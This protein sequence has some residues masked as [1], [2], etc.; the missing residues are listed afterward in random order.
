MSRLPSETVNQRNIQAALQYVT[1]QGDHSQLIMNRL[2]ELLRYVWRIAED[3]EADKV[4]HIAGIRAQDRRRQLR[5]LSKKL[6]NV[7]DELQVFRSPKARSKAEPNF[8]PT[9]PIGLYQLR[10]AAALQLADALSADFIGQFGAEPIVWHR[11]DKSY[12]NIN[13][14]NRL[15]CIEETAE[16][17]IPV[18]LERLSDAL[19]SAAQDLAS[20]TP[21]GGPRA[22]RIRGIILLNV[23]AMWQDIHG[24]KKPASYNR[25]QTKFF[26]FCAEICRSIKFGGECTEAHLRKAV[27]SYNAR[28]LPKT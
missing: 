24:N 3:T 16:D 23:V 10:K 7:V 15:F 18:L 12:A 8:P 6:K 19:E 13:Q 26:N 20:D 11:G 5:S 28:N 14:Q 21:R 17:I 27:K 4:E 2:D 1:A 22:S 9:A 25:G